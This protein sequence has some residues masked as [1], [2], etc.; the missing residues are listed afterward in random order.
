MK[1]VNCMPDK[2]V[3]YERE[4]KIQLNVCACQF[5]A[6]FIRFTTFVEIIHVKKRGL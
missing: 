2:Q 6:R 4:Q 5:V 1:F 3:F